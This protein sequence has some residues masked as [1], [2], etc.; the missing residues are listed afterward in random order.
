VAAPVSEIMVTYS[1]PLIA[2]FLV[3]RNNYPGHKV[4]LAPSQHPTQS[5]MESKPGLPLFLVSVSFLR[6]MSSYGIYKPSLYLTG[7][8]LHLRYRAQPVNAM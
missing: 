8:T 2:G 4:V 3:A 6:R 1:S 5:F 7:D